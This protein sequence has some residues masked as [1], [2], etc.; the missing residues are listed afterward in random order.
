MNTNY[1]LLQYIQESP[2][3][4]HAVE[5]IRKRLLEQGFVELQ[6]K[7]NWT[8]QNGGKYFVTRNQSALM[9]FQIPEGKATGFQMVLSHCDSPCF[10]LKEN[11]EISALGVYTKLNVEGYGG[12]LL[13]PWFDRP[14]SLAGRVMIKTP[15][16]IMPILVN[17]DKDLLMIPSLAIHMNPGVNKGNALNIQEDMLPIMG[18]GELSVK[19][20]MAKRLD[21]P[22]EDILGM[23][24]FVYNRDQ[25]RVW[26]ARDEF[27]ASPRLDNL[28]SVYGSYAGFV[29]SVPKGAIP[30]LGIFD[31]EEV[32]SGTAQGA[33]STFLKDTLWRI[34]NATGGEHR[35][36]LKLLAQSFAISS[37]NA[38]GAHPNAMTKADPNLRP[39]LNGG[40]VIKHSANQK[41]TSDGLSSALCRLLCD[42]TGVP[43]QEFSNRSDMPGGSTLGNLSLSQVAVTSVD[44]GLP[45]W[46]MHSPYESAGAEDIKYLIQLSKAFFSTALDIQEDGIVGWKK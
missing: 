18:M 1:K 24:L 11:P 27:I 41:Y 37:D 15:K 40:I 9:A 38:H 17:A 13:A 4:F 43:Y 33:C 14:L 7:S 2:T 22:P 10:R 16:G 31:N 42:Q 35:D 28:L 5:G 36:Y 39:Q 46:A 20:E 34:V 25:G 21:I 8:I 30:V 12:A 6:E 26:G 29:A 19:S 44:I 23:D 45:Q 3:S 32:G